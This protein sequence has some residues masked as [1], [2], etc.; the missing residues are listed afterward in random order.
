MPAAATIAGDV[1]C[2]R[3]NTMLQ[4]PMSDLPRYFFLSL[5]RFG[6][7]SRGFQCVRDCGAERLQPTLFER[8]ERESNSS[9]CRPERK[10]VR[11]HPIA[12]HLSILH[13][14]REQLFPAPMPRPFFQLKSEPIQIH[15]K[16][17]LSIRA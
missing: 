14:I 7:A 6:V 16:N 5:T 4:E 8:R 9:E 17:S 13:E 3:H 10:A 2:R 15:I 1:E 11:E 12:G